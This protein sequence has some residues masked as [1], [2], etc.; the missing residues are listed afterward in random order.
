MIKKC[1]EGDG[2]TIVW[3]IFW[4]WKF[5]TS[6]NE[7]QLQFMNLI[8]LKFKTMLNSNLND[9]MLNELIEKWN[10]EKF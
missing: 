7:K 9:L 10:Y 5:S 8:L 1:F 3:K 2:N 6:S 4:N